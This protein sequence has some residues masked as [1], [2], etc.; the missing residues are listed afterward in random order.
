MKPRDHTAG[1]TPPELYDLAA[2]LGEKNSVASAN[3]EVATRLTAT[4]GAWRKELVAPVFRGSRVKNEDWGLGDANQK[5]RPKEKP[6]KP[7]NATR[8]RKIFNELS[9][10]LRQCIQLGDAPLGKGHSQRNDEHENKPKSVSRARRPAACDRLPLARA[11]RGPDRARRDV[12]LP[13]S[14]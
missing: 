6:A 7:L 9:T 13:V 5:K 4:L 12:R 1:A 8:N 3:A 10:A 2:D 11:G 14:A